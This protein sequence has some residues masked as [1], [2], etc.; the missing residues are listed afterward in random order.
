MATTMVPPAGRLPDVLPSGRLL[1]SA[2]PAPPWRDEL[3]HISPWRSA[4][5]VAGCWAQALVVLVVAC[6]LSHPVVWVAAFFLMGRSIVMFNILGHE[7]AH[8]LLFRHRRLN[9]EV[10]RWLLA[11]PVFQ[12]LE[13]YRRGHFAHHRDE[14]GP[15]EPDIPLYASYPITRASLRRKLTRD[16]VGITGWKLMRS[17]LRGLR[18]PS[19]RPI[20]VRILAVQ[21]VLLA[22]FTLA[23]R[24]ELYLFLWLLPYMTVWRVFNRL[25][26]IAEHGGMER[27]DDRRQTTHVIRQTW[28][29]RFWIVPYHTGWHL[30]HHVDMAVPWTKLPALHDELVAS[31]WVTPEIT[32]P[33]YTALWRALSSRRSVPVE[34]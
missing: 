18:G 28:L 31:G 33:S 12:P 5:T 30:A 32:Y 17:M 13:L 34:S 15:D 9:D 6:W 10:G 8:R 2:K 16:A 1:A 21:A 24:P 22:L 3:R 7:A 27:S 19:T 26:A 14:L 25:R 20:V 23:G 11:Y 4:L 29:A